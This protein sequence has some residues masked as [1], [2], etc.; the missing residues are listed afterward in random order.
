MK[1]AELT[2]PQGGVIEQSSFIPGMERRFSER[3]RLGMSSSEVLFEILRMYPEIGKISYLYYDLRQTSGH[4]LDNE[5]P[6]YPVD[7]GRVSRGF[8]SRHAGGAGPCDEGKPRW[9]LGIASLVLLKNGEKRHIP[10]ADFACEVSKEN[11]VEVAE[12]MSR[13]RGILAISG[14][15]YHFWGFDL[16]M[17]GEWENFIDHCWRINLERDE[18]VPIL[19][20]GF[21]ESIN[22]RQE[23]KG[24][25]CTALRVCAYPPEKPAEPR[26]V[27]IIPG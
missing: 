21:L 15:S 14:L 18:D 26:V 24:I 3:I 23:W 12:V 9:G 7:V 16:M 5:T 19:C 10:Q 13:Y 1:G 27:K 6:L 4:T 22:Q 11:T 8:L 17:P 25:A 2:F 20:E